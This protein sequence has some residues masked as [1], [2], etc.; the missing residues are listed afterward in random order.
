MNPLFDAI[1]NT[2]DWIEENIKVSELVIELLENTKNAFIKNQEKVATL[3]KEL[4]I[5]H[6]KQLLN[7]QMNETYLQ[8]LNIDK[9]IEDAKK[10]LKCCKDMKD[11]LL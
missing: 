3:Y 7:K 11:K 10:N 1:F 2:E 4:K 6:T 5:E 9:E 8:L